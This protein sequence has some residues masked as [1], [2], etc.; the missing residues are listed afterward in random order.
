M[1]IF[2]WVMGTLIVS[3]FVPSVVLLL[4]YAVTGQAISLFR[5]KTFWNVTRV[6]AMVGMNL[7]IWG[8]VVVGLWQIW[9]R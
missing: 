9:F 2:Y 7:L 6:F 1:R 8:H 4:V 5:A 3:T